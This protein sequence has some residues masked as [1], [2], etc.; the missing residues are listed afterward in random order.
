MKPFAF[1]L[2]RIRDYRIQ[3]L[4]TEKNLLM[5]LFRKLYDIEDKIAL[6]RKF[7]LEK[8]EEMQEKQMQGL[9][10]RELE[11]CKFYLENMRIQLEALEEEREQAALEVERQRVVVVKCSQDVSSLDK[12]EEKQL[13]DYHYLEARDSEKTIQEQVIR[14]LV[15]PK[16]DLH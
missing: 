11:E 3:V 15:Y 13:E 16:N 1:S 2:D 5:E 12:L 4:D 14:S 8:Q 6:C 10:M 7:R 9:T